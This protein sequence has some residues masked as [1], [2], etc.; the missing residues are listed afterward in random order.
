MAL[1]Q[2]ALTADIIS[3]AGVIGSLLYLAFEIRRQNRLNRLSAANI[4][5]SQWSELMKSLHEVPEMSEIWL[6]G[7]GDFESLDGVERLRFGT[8]FG[9]FLK[10][11]EGL[12]LHVL[13]KSLDP[14]VRRGTERTIR[15]LMS[16]PG[17]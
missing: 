15:D 11:S 4:L 5:A 1:E 10:N 9:R 17:S 8:Y 14:M 3:G 16:L 7:T 13:D 12:Y 2:W 6:K